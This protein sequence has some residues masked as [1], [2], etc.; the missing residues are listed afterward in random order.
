MTL[1]PHGRD[2]YTNTKRY[3]RNK[4]I[5]RKETKIKRKKY[6]GE[7][8]KNLFHEKIEHFVI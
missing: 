7:I 5:G 6:T 2:I 4:Q 8:I 1:F 3:R